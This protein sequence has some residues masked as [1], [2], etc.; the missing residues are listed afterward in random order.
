[1]GCFNNRAKLSKRCT[2]SDLVGLYRTNIVYPEMEG[3]DQGG[4]EQ[5]WIEAVI[6]KLRSQLCQTPSELW[7]WVKIFVY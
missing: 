6:Q 3:L 2:R 4:E 5:P 7:E 1:M